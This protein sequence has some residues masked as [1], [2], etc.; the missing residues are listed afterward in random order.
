M[1]TQKS[2]SR[3]PELV[4]GSSLDPLDAL[5][6][7]LANREDLAELSDDMI[8][9]ARALIDDDMNQKAEISTQLSIQ[10]EDLDE[11]SRQLRLL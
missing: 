10:E 2:R 9:A 6:T 8:V 3:L 4:P 11:A 7:Y 5:Q 1:V